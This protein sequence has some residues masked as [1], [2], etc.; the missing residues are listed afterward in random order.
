MVKN[1]YNLNI[2]KNDLD[3]FKDHSV[4]EKYLQVYNNLK[5]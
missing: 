3:Q 5:K 4:A 2:D 1:S